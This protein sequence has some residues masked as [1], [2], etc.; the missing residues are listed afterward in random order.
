MRCI[1]V[2]VGIV[3]LGCQRAPVRTT[4]SPADVAAIQS[5]FDSWV[6]LMETGRYD[7]LNML[8]TPDFTFVM[9][10]RRLSFADVRTMINT[11][12][13]TELDIRLSNPTAH[14]SGDMGYLLLDDHATFRS[15]GMPVTAAEVALVVFRRGADRWRIAAW[16][17]TSPPPTAAS[18]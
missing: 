1:A 3:M 14:V 5:T 4:D 18:K 13:P 9:E 8:V 16:M 10:G 12:Q 7:S 11:I 17:V 2:A 6:R 15:G